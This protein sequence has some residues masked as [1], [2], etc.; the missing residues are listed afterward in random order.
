MK[1]EINVKIDKGVH[2][3]PKRDFIGETKWRKAQSNS[4]FADALRYD[5]LERWDR[6]HNKTEDIDYVDV[7]NDPVKCVDYLDLLPSNQND[8][9]DWDGLKRDLPKLPFYENFDG[10]IANHVI[11]PVHVAFFGNDLDNK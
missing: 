1:K 4:H 6:L 8:K 5:F 3:I 7:T 11:D 10:I 2:D 9:L